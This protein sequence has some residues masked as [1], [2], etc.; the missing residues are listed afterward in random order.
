M[1]W[2]CSAAQFDSIRL[3]CN[4][5]S[6]VGKGIFLQKADGHELARQEAH[7]A[8]RERFE[9]EVEDSIELVKG[10]THVEA[11]F[12]GGQSLAAS[13]LHDGNAFDIEPSKGGRVDGFDDDLFFCFEASAERGDA[14]LDKVET[15]TLHDIV[16]GVLGGRDDFF[17]NAES[18]ADF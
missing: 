16:F 13:G 1:T 14:I 6:V 4:T 2:R 10:N 5:K 3:L 11:D 18:G 17:G 12:G 7:V 9:A 15:G 8:V